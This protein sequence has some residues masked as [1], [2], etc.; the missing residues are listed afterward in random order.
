MVL[1]FMF[2]YL[3]FWLTR[4][5]HDPEIINGKP[6]FK[7]LI[8]PGVA[9][10]YMAYCYLSAFFINVFYNIYMKKRDKIHDVFINQLFV[11]FMICDFSTISRVENYISFCAI[12]VYGALIGFSD[13]YIR[14]RHYKIFFHTL[15][16]EETVNIV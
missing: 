7:K 9:L 2:V 8:G 10:P 12:L 11:V 16:E 4:V 15:T 3:G 1:Y 5:V 6:V 13:N 14:S